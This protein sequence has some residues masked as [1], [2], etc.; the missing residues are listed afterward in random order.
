[1]SYNLLPYDQSQLLLMPPSVQEWVAEGSLARFVSDTVDELDARGKLKAF[2]ATLRTDGWG[3]AA[4]PPR[5]MVKIV[6]YGCSIGVRSSRKLDQA[7]G[8]DVCFRYLAGNLHPD[9][10]T[11]SRFRVDHAE[12]LDGLFVSVLELCS[13]AG[14]V[15]LGQ[16]ALDGRRVAGNAALERNRTKADLLEQVR[17][18]RKEAEAIDTA[19]DELYGADK[20]G[21]EL[22]E[23]LQTREG[24]LKAIRGALDQLEKPE[25]ELRAAHKK[26]LEARAE[27]EKRT[28]KPARGRKPK[29]REDKIERM[30]AN[31]T[32]PESRTMKTRKG[33]VQGYN[34]QALVDCDSQVIVAQDLRQE[35]VDWALLKPMLKQCEAQ[36]GARPK[37]C[38]ADGG[39]FSEANGALEDRRTKL[40]MAV[41]SA[42]EVE[43]RSDNRIRKKRPWKGRHAVK[44]RKRL[45]TEEGRATYKLRSSTVEPVF[46]QMYE[47]GLN[48]F[49]LRGL[50]KV[51]GEWA[52]WST[53]HNLLKLWRAVMAPQPI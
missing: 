7:L 34:G 2:Y 50:R 47:R 15:K 41:G 6:L 28:G 53:S 48:R 31:T 17:K 27:E 10:R 3:R 46:G 19:E 45:A 20:R 22:P 30:R 43:G 52:L 32:D 4:Y 9:F 44:M 38:L 42:A 5:M 21:D 1:M 24:R 13:E 36:A 14:L 18:L 35:A 37:L 51:S 39:Y 29:L 11:L 12:A 33:Y 26:K 8:H 49:L 40:L 23:A 16:V 25:E